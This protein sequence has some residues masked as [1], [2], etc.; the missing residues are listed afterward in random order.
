MTE[1]KIGRNS[2]LKALR[3]RAP[4]AMH[5]MEVVASLKVPKSR[6]DEVRDVLDELRGLGMVKEMPGYRFRM[7]EKPK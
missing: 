4:K 3:E 5:L 7:G 6:R 2:V 1:T